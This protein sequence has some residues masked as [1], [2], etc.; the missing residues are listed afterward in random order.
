MNMITNVKATAKVDG[1]NIDHN[2][3]VTT[4]EKIKQTGNV[5]VSVLCDVGKNRKNKYDPMK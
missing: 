3:N 1:E 5:W 4:I 2:K